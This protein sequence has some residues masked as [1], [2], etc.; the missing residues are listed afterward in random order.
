M[1]ARRLFETRARAPAASPRQ[2]VIYALALI[3]A[4]LSSRLVCLFVLLACIYVYVRLIALPLRALVVV[5][6]VYCCW[7]VRVLFSRSF[8]CG[9]SRKNLS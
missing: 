7:C 9:G 3:C 5:A 4:E 2:R 8:C 1:Q 6:V